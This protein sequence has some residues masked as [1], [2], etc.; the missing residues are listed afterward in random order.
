MRKGGRL[1]FK[2]SGA[3]E[4]QLGRQL[5]PL[6][7]NDVR[8]S[9]ALQLRGRGGRLCHLVPKGRSTAQAGSCAQSVCN[10][11]WMAVPA[12]F[13]PLNLHLLSTMLSSVITPAEEH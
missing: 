8:F 11:H 7:R 12:H 2:N 6:L 9:T 13:T 5:A 1:R 10:D 3:V 4:R